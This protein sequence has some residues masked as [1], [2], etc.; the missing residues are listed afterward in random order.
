M[1]ECTFLHC[2]GVRLFFMKTDMCLYIKL[3]LRSLLHSTTSWYRSMNSNHRI[4]SLRA[5]LRCSNTDC[6]YS[7]A[8]A[9]SFSRDC[10]QAIVSKSTSLG[11]MYRLGPVCLRRVFRTDYYC[12][13]SIH[14]SI[15]PKKLSLE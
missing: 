9:S 13:N 12:I 5:Q 7:S 11:S 10:R 8:R 1:S 3:D 4:F 2:Y 14:T 15:A 6:F